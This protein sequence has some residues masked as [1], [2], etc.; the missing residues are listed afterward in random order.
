MGRGTIKVK[1]I[2]ES[3]IY[4]AEKDYDKAFVTKDNPEGEFYFFLE[5]LNLYCDINDVFFAYKELED[6]SYIVEGEGYFPYK[7]ETCNRYIRDLKREI[8]ELEKKY[9]GFRVKYKKMS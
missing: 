2:D 5:P 9:P 7:K 3:K 8:K 1:R 6:G 4:Y